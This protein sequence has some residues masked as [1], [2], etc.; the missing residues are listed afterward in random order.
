LKKKGRNPRGVI[1]VL[2]FDKNIHR[3][4]DLEEGMVLPGM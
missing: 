2:E 3:I 1:K 4:D